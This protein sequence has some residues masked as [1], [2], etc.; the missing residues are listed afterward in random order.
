MDAPGLLRPWML[1]F[2]SDFGLSGFVDPEQAVMLMELIA[3]EG[4]FPQLVASA[5]F[6]KSSQG[7]LHHV[8]ESCT[9]IPCLNCG[10][11]F[12]SDPDKVGVEKLNM[13]KVPPEYL[14]A[15]YEELPHLNAGSHSSSEC[16]L[17]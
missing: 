15:P 1:G 13:T 11:R 16:L 3:L 12:N 7:L 14:E 8:H 9:A 5:V 17:S 2:R 6:M 4:S 10:L